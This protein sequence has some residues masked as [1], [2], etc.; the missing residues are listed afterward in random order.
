MTHSPD[1]V[2]PASAPGSGA[3]LFRLQLKVVPK[4]SAD[5]I[6]GWMGERLKIQ[7]RAAPERGRANRAVVELLAEALGLPRSSIRITAGETSPQKT[8]QIQGDP[9]LLGRLPAR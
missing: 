1:S 7:V 4:A 9:N 2:P 3:R 8:V 5:R 6:V